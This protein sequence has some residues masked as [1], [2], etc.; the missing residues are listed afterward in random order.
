MSGTRL[1]SAVLILTTVTS[2]TA[3]PQI[4]PK[5]FT[6][7]VKNPTLGDVLRELSEQTGLSI[8]ASGLDRKTPA[9]VAFDNIPFWS[10]LDQTAVKTGSKIVLGDHGR[11]VTLAK[12]TGPPQPSS[13]DGPFRVAV[14]QV[15]PRID[16]DTGRT[17]VD[18]TLDIHWE[19]R[20][21]VFRLDAQP[22]LTSLSADVGV[23]TARTVKAKTNPTGSLYS[24]AVRIEGVPRSAT[25]LTRVAGRFI[26]TASPTMLPFVFDSLAGPFPAVGKPPPGTTLRLSAVLKRFEPVGDMWEA[27]VVV[28]YPKGPEFETFETWV[29]ENRAR[30]VS[31]GGQPIASADHEHDA[32]GGRVSGVYRF[33]VPPG[34]RKGWSLVY[35]TPAPLVEFPVTFDLRDVPL[36]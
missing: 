27:E 24:T 11:H 35:E 8:D 30:L 7:N 12:R 3:G 25:K 21:P 22:I 19:P 18:M 1:L 9:P 14:R 29:T 36:P 10:V 13:T 17:F 20:F 33:K 2:L 16:F 4:P 31:P 32:A 5:T 15:N 26:V 34:D 23:P 28:T 6:L